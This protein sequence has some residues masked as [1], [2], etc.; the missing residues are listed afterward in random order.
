MATK[1]VFIYIA[2]E[3]D[4][5]MHKAFIDSPIVSLTVA[6]VKNYEEAEIAAKELVK[7]TSRL[8]NS[9]PDL[10]MT[11]WHAFQS[12]IRKSIRRCRLI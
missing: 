5:K 11:V 9:V 1:A 2:S 6:G 3:N 4:Y 12:N 8:L 10:G 7:M